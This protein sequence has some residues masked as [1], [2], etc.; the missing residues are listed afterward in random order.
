MFLVR[1][2]VDF[3]KQVPIAQIAVL[4]GEDAHHLGVLGP[5]GCT[6]PP[7]TPQKY[8]FCQWWVVFSVCQCPAV[9]PSDALAEV[10]QGLSGAPPSASSTVSRAPDATVSRAPDATDRRLWGVGCC[11]HGARHPLS[12]ATLSARAIVG[13]ADSM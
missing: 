10:D 8:S 2:A 1:A 11:A 7:H 9:L 12:Q 13:E 6:A 3:P 5:P 4:D